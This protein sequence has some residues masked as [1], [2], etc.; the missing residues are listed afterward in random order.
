MFMKRQVK[1][2][3]SEGCGLK[4]Q[5]HLQVSN[6]LKNGWIGVVSQLQ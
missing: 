1:N 6:V 5:G 4:S 2:I 3:I